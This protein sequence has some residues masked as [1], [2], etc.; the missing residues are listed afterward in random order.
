MKN[1]W[2]AVSCKKGWIREKSKIYDEADK[3]RTP[4]KRQRKR[5]AAYKGFDKD[6]YKCLLNARH[7]NELVNGSWKLCWKVHES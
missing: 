7:Q 6:C 5:I 2:A 3:N 4:E 1:V